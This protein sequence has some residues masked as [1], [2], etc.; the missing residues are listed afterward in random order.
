MLFPNPVSLI[1]FGI[2]DSTDRDICVLQPGTHPAILGLPGCPGRNCQ[3]LCDP[4]GVLPLSFRNGRVV[5][6]FLPKL[7]SLQEAYH[8]SPPHNPPLTFPGIILGVG[9]VGRVGG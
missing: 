4:P 2:N 5:L 8:L 6:L 7:C 9:G 3:S 1:M